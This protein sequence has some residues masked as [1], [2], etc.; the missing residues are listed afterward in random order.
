MYIEDQWYAIQ[1]EI[2][3]IPRKLNTVKLKIF[4]LYQINLIYLLTPTRQ[5]EIKSLQQ[6]D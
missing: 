6:I 2:K 5:K 4:I 3:F 1:T